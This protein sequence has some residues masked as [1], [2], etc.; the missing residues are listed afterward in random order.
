MKAKETSSA[1]KIPRESMALAVVSEFGMALAEDKM[2]VC[3]SWALV[4]GRMVVIG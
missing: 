3:S 2:S 1:G 4:D